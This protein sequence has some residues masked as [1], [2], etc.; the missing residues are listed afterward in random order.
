MTLSFASGRN[1]ADNADNALSDTAPTGTDDNTWVVDNTAP[2]VTITG[3]PSASSAAFTATFTFSE[4]VTGFV[5]GDITVG[6]GAA[7]AFTATTAGRVYR[8]SITPAVSGTVTV[9]VAASAARDAAGNG[10]PAATRATS[11]YT[12]P[13]VATAPGEPASLTAR[14]GD[15]QVTLIWTPPA[16]DGG[17]P[18]ERYQYRHSAG[19]TVASRAPWMDVPDADSDGSLADER[20]VTVPDLDNARQYAF[21]VRAVNQAVNG[22]AARAVAIPVRAPLPPRVRFPGQQFR[23]ARG[24]RRVRFTVTQDIVG[25][26]TIGARGAEL[27]NIEFRL[28]T[29]RP[30]MRPASDSLGHALPSERDGHPGGDPGRTGG[31]AHRGAG[32]RRDRRPARRPW[33]S[34]R[35]AAPTSRR[36]PRTWWCWSTTFPVSVESTTFPAEDA[37]G[38]RGWAV[39]G[40]GAGN[41]SPWSY[42]TTGSLLMRVYGTPDGATVATAPDAPAG[43]G[44]SGGRC[45]R[46]ADLGA[47]EERRRGAYREIPV[48]LL[49]RLQGRSGDGLDRRARRF[50][51]R[52]PPCRRTLGHRHGA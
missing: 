40:I 5:A 26:F 46:E 17:A 20:S 25:V 36:A 16:L 48:P 45:A 13:L 37:G 29:R 14:A 33:P 18:I 12:A 34:P 27:H 8:A 19:S 43:L 6:N 4:E 39:D 30:N 50:G 52:Q 23:A 38:A 24:R 15:A 42:G 2:T 41:S 22:R 10:N 47:A 11:T 51:Y 21:E 1:I 28:F 32:V 49:G 9:D 31:G 3:V 44:V 35:R 7:S